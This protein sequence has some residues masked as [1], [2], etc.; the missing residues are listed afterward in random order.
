M[1]RWV[2]SEENSV[3]NVKLLD[4]NFAGRGSRAGEHEGRAKLRERGTGVGRGLGGAGEG[5]VG[6]GGGAGGRGGGLGGRGGGG[7]GV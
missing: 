5:G 4:A 6:G 1:R 2:T 7:R 3:E